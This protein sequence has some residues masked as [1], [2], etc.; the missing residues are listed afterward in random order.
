MTAPITLFFIKFFTEEI[1]ADQ[2]MAGELY[3]NTLSYFKRTENEASDG[4]PDSTEG[5]AMWWQPDDFLMKLNMPGIGEADITNKDLAAPVSM[6]F[7]HHN[8]AHVFCLYAMHI[9]GF[10]LLRDGKI[11][12]SEAGPD[13]LQ[14]QL[15]VDERCFKFGKF[16]VVINAVPFIN[17]LRE[18]LISQGRKFRCKLVEYYDETTFHGTIPTKEIPFRKQRRFSYQQEFRVCIYPTVITDSPIKIKIGDISTM[19]GKLEASRLN[20]I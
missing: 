12:C 1:H 16:A 18:A 17:K 15:R 6:S 20:S 13:E 9:T 5:V 7:D 3:L 8:Y 19:C 10:T 11:D 2:F 4:R 14:R